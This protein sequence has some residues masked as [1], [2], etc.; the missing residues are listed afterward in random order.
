MCF[1]AHVEGDAEGGA[2]RG[3][4]ESRL[5]L[6][7]IITI[8]FATRAG[9]TNGAMLVASVGRRKAALDAAATAP[10]GAKLID[11]LHSVE[12]VRRDARVRALNE[13]VLPTCLLAT[14]QARQTIGVGG[15]VP[16]ANAAG[17]PW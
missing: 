6:V 11:V 13:A 9:A 16:T 10:I 7:V 12:E 4:G 14:E 5:A 8:A 15:A 17:A 2:L 3:A 1:Q